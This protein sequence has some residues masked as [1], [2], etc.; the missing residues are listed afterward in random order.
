MR[1]LCQQIKLKYLNYLLLSIFFG[2]SCSSF[3]F[4]MKTSSSKMNS[5]IFF[6]ISKLYSSLGFNTLYK[7]NIKNKDLTTRKLFLTQKKVFQKNSYELF[8]FN[9]TQSQKGVK[10][11]CFELFFFRKNF[12]FYLRNSAEASNFLD[13]FNNY[14][15]FRCVC[16]AALEYIKILII[17]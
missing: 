9:I 14:F 6:F 4:L 5:A 11:Q 13:N 8:F 3:F 16:V 17:I 10:K 12:K 2:F 1:Q 7:I 15:S